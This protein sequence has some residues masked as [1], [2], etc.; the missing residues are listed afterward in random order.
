MLSAVV[1]SR[2]GVDEDAE[3]F[4]EFLLEADFQFSRDIVDA[5]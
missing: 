5:R 3:Q 1:G 4:R 2:L